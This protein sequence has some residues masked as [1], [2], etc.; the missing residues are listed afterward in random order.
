MKR[1]EP[2]DKI[3]PGVRKVID[4]GLKTLQPELLANIH[5]VFAMVLTDFDLNFV[6]EELPDTR[7]DLLRDQV[8][9][10]VTHARAKLDGPIATEWAKATKGD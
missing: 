9:S 8:K 2:F 1:G 10:L 4:D 3:L 7:R 6:V 5:E